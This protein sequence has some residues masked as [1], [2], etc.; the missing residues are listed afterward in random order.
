[1]GCMIRGLKP[2][3]NKRFFSFLT[4]SRPALGPTQPST[5]WV[6]STV[7]QVG[8]KWLRHEADHSPPSNAKDKNEWSYTPHSAICLHD[9]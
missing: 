6:L 3:R 7:S 8:V 5:H 2:G 4:T 1:M 9:I